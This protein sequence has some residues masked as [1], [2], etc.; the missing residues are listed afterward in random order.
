MTYNISILNNGL[1]VC[2]EFLPG[3]ESVAV[4][5]SVDVGARYEEP[6]EGG[7]SHLLEHMAFKGTH[8]RSARRIAEEFD[9]IG[10]QFNAYTSMEQTVYY[11]KVLKEHV[12][13][14]VDI[15][16]DILQHSVFD[17][18][19]LKREQEVIQQELAMHIDTP[20]D[21]IFDLFDETAFP[22]QPMGRSI[23]GT[24]ELI[25]S[26]GREDVMAY[27][28]KHYQPS[29]MIVSAAGNIKHADF[30][31]WAG[32]YF[33]LT[34]SGIVPRPMPAVYGGGELRRSRKLEQLHLLTGLEAV[35][36]K[37][38]DFY[39]L[40]AFSSVLGGGMSSRLFQEVRE[41]RGLA[42]HV[43]SM[44]SAYADVGVLCVYTASGA[45]KAKE[46][47]IILMDEIR[48]MGEGVSLEE[49][50]RAK[51]QQKAELLMARE[52]PST[53]AGWIGRHL[54]VFDRY[55]ELPEILRHIDAV[56]QADI[57]R[58]AEKL[59]ASKLTLAALGPIKGLP[60][61]ETVAAQLES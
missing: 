53:V 55:I 40:Q 37:D 35:S 3:V 21:L 20:D 22:D 1:R 60:K 33:T 4:A 16:A 54:L 9:S 23:L 42:Y 59:C 38:P 14:A 49:L 10:G 41:K 43:S 19:E 44:V 24:A 7:I 46:L 29:R 56:Q 57:T 15:L 31:Q 8:A 17:A 5:V 2:S 34:E 47:P 36:V 18:E 50:G 32:D 58:M 26:H 27:M 30:V 39:A 52:N 12:P 51:N 45:D 61:Y 11:T 28:Q 48:R 25:A 6:Q 13:V